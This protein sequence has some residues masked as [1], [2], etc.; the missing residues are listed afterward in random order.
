MVWYNNYSKEIEKAI[1]SKLKGSKFIL[2]LMAEYSI[3][4]SDIDKHLD[5]Q[6][7]DLGG[8]YAEGNSKVI[9]IDEKIV[10]GILNENFHFII[11]EMWHWIKRRHEKLF[12]FNDS[13]EVQ[14]F[15][16]AIAWEMYSGRERELYKK[17]YPIVD[18][19]FRDDAVAEDIF[20]S[21][22]EHARELCVKF[23]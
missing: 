6:I 5:I 23:K 12:Y 4:V 17:I 1:K 8:G 22:C 9:R 20:E 15:I 3:P 18:S 19:H 2:T 10:E 16:W 13:E 14:A 7:T 21:M 11:H